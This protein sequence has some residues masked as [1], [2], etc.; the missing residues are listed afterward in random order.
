M[1]RRAEEAAFEVL[2]ALHEQEG[3][4]LHDG[5]TRRNILV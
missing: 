3:D 5:V 4:S 1:E 2:V